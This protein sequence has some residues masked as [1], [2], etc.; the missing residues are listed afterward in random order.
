MFYEQSTASGGGKG[1]SWKFLLE[2]KLLRG[3]FQTNSSDVFPEI[4]LELARFACELEAG[5]SG[6]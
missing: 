4:I 5:T 1:K 6:R 3:I 2:E